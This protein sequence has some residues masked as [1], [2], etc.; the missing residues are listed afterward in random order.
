MLAEITEAG[1]AE[2]GVRGRVCR[3]VGVAV[4]DEPT[5]AV[6]PAAAE[7]EH[8]CVVVRV[9]MDVEPLSDPNH[10]IT[11]LPPDHPRPAP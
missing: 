5:L 8:S 2:Q 3:D 4:P 6:E 10:A 1:R 11:R 9:S 7:H